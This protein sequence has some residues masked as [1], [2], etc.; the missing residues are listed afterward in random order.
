MQDVGLFETSSGNHSGQRSRLE[1]CYLCC[2]LKINDSQEKNIQQGCA[3]AASA[4]KFLTK[5][6]WSPSPAKSN[7][8]STYAQP[9]PS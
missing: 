5:C 1:F 2:L 3:K 6:L 7:C 9:A 4:S 8:E